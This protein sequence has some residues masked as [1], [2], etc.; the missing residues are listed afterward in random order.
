MT[1][2]PPLLLTGCTL[3]D[4]TGTP[5]Q[6]DREL[7]IEGGRIAHSAPAGTTPAPADPGRLRVITLDGATVLPGLIDCHTHMTTVPGG[8]PMELITSP[9]ALRILRAARFLEQTL[10]AGVTTVRDLSG[11][12]SG[13]R[14]AVEEGTAAGPRLLI[15]IRILSITGGHG[16]WRAINGTDLT[17]GS[18]G[19]AVADG[20]DAFVRATRE[21]IR[22][23]ADWIKVAASG[24]MSS[25]RSDPQHGG[26]TRAEMSA[27]VTEADRHG[28]MGVA[29]HAQ[30]TSAIADAVAAGVRSIEH[31]YGIDDTSIDEMGERGTVLVPTLSALT[32]SRTGDS[33][34]GAGGIRPGD[35]ERRRRFRDL[36]EERIRVALSS[37]IQVAMG[38][39]AGIAGH[40]RNA[41]EIA[42]LVRFGLSPMRAI[43]A[44]TSAAAALCGVADQVGTLREGMRA[45]LVALARDP[46]LD[47]GVFEDPGTVRL[48]VQ[49][50]TIVRGPAPWPDGPAGAPAVGVRGTSPD[51]EVS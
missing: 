29:A 47:P 25:P 14:R 46:L 8:D 36:A 10:Q 21:V 23:G 48:V 34:N 7:L 9:P 27:V 2:A 13:L 16:D 15:A 45:D 18:G 39:D 32:R 37:G 5:A 3:I 38:T 28:G 51:Q 17:G 19:G 1:G 41:R 24:G 31:G 50:G 42:L 6:P 33:R 40:G 4:G 35:D 12:D 49:D 30:G 26:L 43:V 44:A 11:A 20:P 22:D